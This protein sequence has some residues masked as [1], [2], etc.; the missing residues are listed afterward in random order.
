[1]DPPYVAFTSKSQ[2][3]I[4]ITSVHNQHQLMAPYHH[5]HPLPGVNLFIKMLNKNHP[6]MIITVT[7]SNSLQ[8]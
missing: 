4:D 1:M 2:D 6:M 8:S 5:Y 7:H 3:I